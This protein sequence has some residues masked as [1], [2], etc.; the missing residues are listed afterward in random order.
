[1]SGNGRPMR[2]GVFEVDLHTGELRKQGLRIKLR[3]QPFQILLL[4]LAHPGEVVSRDELQKQLW[5]ADTFV[6]FER[7]LNKAVN[8]LRDALGDSAESPRFIETL[9]K[10]G[11][12]FI[13]PVDAGHPNGHV[14]AERPEPWADAQPLDTREATR[15]S[16]LRFSAA[17]PWMIASLFA[18]IAVISVALLWRATRPAD[19]PM[20]R[21]SVDLGP[22]AIRGRAPSGEFFNPVISP[23]GTHLVFPVK[24]AG[25]NQQLGMRR[26]EQSTVTMLAGP[27]GA[28]DP[29][30][31]PDGQWIGFFAGQKLKKIPL[32]GGGAVSLCDTTGLE[33]GASWGKDGAI[34]ANLDG[35][36]LFRVPV[37]GG[38]PRVVG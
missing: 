34:I 30:F 15:G 37:M 17:L 33:R 12:R 11:Y 10:R 14:L 6:D 31:S 4:L 26:L 1:M 20:M 22:E 8:H 38:E 13:A 21:L 2:F 27:E 18:V 9:P 19:R 25:G 7:G 35:D 23:A 28:V 32:Q 3:D 36:H 29:F 16:K 5:L 24:P